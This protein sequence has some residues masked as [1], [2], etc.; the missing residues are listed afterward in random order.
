MHPKVE[1]ALRKL[2]NAEISEYFVTLQ[3]VVP[4]PLKYRFNALKQQ[5]ING[6]PG[7]DFP[8]IL[9]TFAREVDGYY[10]CNVNPNPSPS[11]ENNPMAKIRKLIA[12]GKIEQAFQQLNQRYQ[13]ELGNELTL[14]QSRYNRY[15]RDQRMGIVEDGGRELNRIT[16]ALLELVKSLEK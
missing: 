5:F 3:E 10:N 4:D 11:T 15:L 8:Q 2:Q 14:L 1:I 16:Y 13:S 12:E 9:E 6:N 7:W